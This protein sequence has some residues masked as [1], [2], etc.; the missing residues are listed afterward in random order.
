MPLYNAMGKEGTPYGA[1]LYAGDPFYHSD[2]GIYNRTGVGYERAFCK[3]RIKVKAEMVFKT[4]GEQLY[5][6]Q[7]VAL[8]VNLAP[9]LYDKTNK[10]TK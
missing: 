8:G 6:Q 9:K 3:E 2:N 4:E 10:K 7:I 1:D 5:T